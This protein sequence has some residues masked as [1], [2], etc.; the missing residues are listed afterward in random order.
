VDYLVLRVMTQKAR[1]HSASDPAHTYLQAVRAGLILWAI[2]TMGLI[3]ACTILVRKN[4][5]LR[6]Q[7]EHHQP[8]GG[9]S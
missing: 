3:V 9:I 2:L 1:E 8:N 4:R 5:I 6:D 7:Q